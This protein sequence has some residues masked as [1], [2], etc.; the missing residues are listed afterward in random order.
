MAD[1]SP[2]LGEERKSNFGDVRAA[3]D[4]RADIR[5]IEILQC[6]GFLRAPELSCLRVNRFTI[7]SSESN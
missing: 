3:V 5:R 1:L 4:P 6:S 2:L 7:G